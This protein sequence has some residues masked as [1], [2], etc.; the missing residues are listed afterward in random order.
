MHWNKISSN[1][2]ECEGCGE[3]MDIRYLETIRDS[4]GR[5]IE[6]C[7]SCIIDF[8]EDNSQYK[9]KNEDY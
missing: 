3:K 5:N 2:V 4:S 1:I 9:N 7:P 6:L 8:E